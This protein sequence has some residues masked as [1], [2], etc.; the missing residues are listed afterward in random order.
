MEGSELHILLKD[1]EKYSKSS[2]I[3]YLNINS[4]R[5]KIVDMRII[6]QDLQLNYFVSNETK[7]DK[8]FPTSQFHL[9]DS[10]KRARKDRN[11]NIEV[12]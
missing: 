1:R 11:K 12:D 5:D 10:E 8:K 4:F 9:S 6:L 2:L 7:L 3:D